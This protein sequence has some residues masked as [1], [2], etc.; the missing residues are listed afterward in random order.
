MNDYLAQ[1]TDDNEF[2][3]EHGHLD[4]PRNCPEQLCINC[5]ICSS[6]KTT[7]VGHQDTPQKR[8]SVPMVSILSVLAMRPAELEANTEIMSALC[9]KFIGRPRWH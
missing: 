8:N 3:S 4:N 6:P 9:Y 7:I 5:W 1:K 2:S